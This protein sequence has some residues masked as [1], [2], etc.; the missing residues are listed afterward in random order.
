MNK[1]LSVSMASVMALSLAACGGQQ[2]AP[3]QT[4]GNA[5]AA[6]TSQEPVKVKFYT[7]KKD[8]PAEPT[9][10]AVEAF[11]KKHP[12]IQ[13]EYVSLVQNSDAREF[14][15]K[16]DVMMAA[17]EAVDVVHFANPDLLM[18]RAG[19][20]V[21]EPLNKY[22]EKAKLKPEEE[23]L[24]SPTFNGN[25][26]GMMLT[27]QQWFVILNQKHLE[28]AKLPIPQMGWTWDD[29]RDYA[30]KLTKGEGKDKRY[31]AYF[32]N[33]GEHANMIAYS[34]LSHPQ[35]KPDLT[36]N[37]EHPS[38]KYFFELRRAMEKDDKSVEPFADVL[39]AKYHI[40]QQFYSGKASMA[41]VGSYAINVAKDEKRFPHDFKTVFAPMPRSSKDA[42]LGNTQITGAYLG[43]GTKTK[44][45]DEAF[46]FMRWMTTEGAGLLGDLPGW[47]KSDG[48]A[49]MTQI[50]GD[51]TNLVDL[52]SLIAT[53]FDK[54]I[55]T[56]S[57]PTDIT[58]NQELKKVLENGFTK[59]LLDNTKYEDVQKTMADEAK[60]IVEAN[61]K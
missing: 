26:Y 10:I 22:F 52:D 30:K 1:W 8:D 5:P 18:E 11:N 20:G 9:K 16:L 21:F 13:V 24:T 56:A 36:P 6:Q 50:V 43:M 32:H 34:E 33:L 57:K 54:R 48:K 17:G 15:K 31:G 58:Y 42:E 2:A 45:K 27:A 60:K 44:H 12:A 47:K 55:K 49:I 39:A 46:T 25:V 35:L 59:F 28:E 61:K 29:F 40:L 4:K 38:F 19:R 7:F 14:M 53:A 51:K 23:Y 37:F 3:E 41:A